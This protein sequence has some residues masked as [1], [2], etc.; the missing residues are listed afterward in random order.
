MQPE[1]RLSAAVQNEGYNKKSSLA[2]PPSIPLAAP[3]RP[4]AVNGN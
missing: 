4:T 2:R 1:S 3:S